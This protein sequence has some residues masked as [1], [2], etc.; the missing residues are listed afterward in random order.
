MRHWPASND[1]VITIFVEKF[2][3]RG[4]KRRRAKS[5]AQAVELSGRSPDDKTS[6]VAAYDG[7]LRQVIVFVRLLIP[8]EV[9]RLTILNPLLILFYSPTKV[10]NA[11]RLLRRSTKIV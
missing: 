1:N 4:P 6:T 7:N 5:K 11:T 2:G 9:A 3:S 8:A 10:K